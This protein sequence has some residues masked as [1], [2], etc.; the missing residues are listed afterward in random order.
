MTNQP[1]PLI[2]VP[3]KSVVKICCIEG[4]HGLIQKL[5]VMGIRIGQRI[6]M[7]SKQPFRG[8]VTIKVNGREL[9]IGRGMAKKILVEVVS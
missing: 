8:P 1:I 2:S 5:Q 3:A 9:T 6:V 4:G 7:A